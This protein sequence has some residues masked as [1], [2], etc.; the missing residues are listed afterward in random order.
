MYEFSLDW[1]ENIFRA[2]VESVPANNVLK[3]R[4]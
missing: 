3:E 4:L 2:S 1:F